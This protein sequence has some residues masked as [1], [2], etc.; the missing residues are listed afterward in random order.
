MQQQQQGEH[1]SRE[2]ALLK[3]PVLHTER[4]EAIRSKKGYIIDM[5]GVIYHGANLLPGAK[6]LV[7]FLQDNNK[8]YLFLT[9]NSAPTPQELQQKLHRLGIDVGAEHFFTCGQATALF[10]ESQMPSGGTC[11]VIGEPGLAYALYEKGFYMNDHNPDYVVLGETAAINFE[12][13]TKAVQLVQQGAKLIATNL[14][15]ET[16]DSQGRKIPSTGAFAA[17]IELVT[18]TQAFYCGK[19]SALIMRYAQR[20]LGLSRLETC[21]IGDRMDTDIV[22]GITSEIDPVLVLSG[23]TQMDDLKEFAY[24]PYLILGGVYEIPSDDESHRVT[25]EELEEASRRA[26]LL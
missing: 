22:A 3:D 14:D 15:V 26:S 25:E 7:Q 19:P 18:K 4:L 20:V 2:W 10:L 1:L 17:S 21:I 23:V 8:K 5:D 11:Y 9:N 24:G 13:I 16:L 6:E 12:K